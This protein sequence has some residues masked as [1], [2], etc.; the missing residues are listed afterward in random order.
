MSANN[1][2]P[3]AAIVGL[4]GAELGA[5][6]RRLFAKAQPLGFI[7]FARNVETKSQVK[8]LVDDLRR[9][10][11]RNA[12]VLIDQEGGRVQRLKP[13]HWRQAPPA[14]VFGEL[15]NRNVE[16]A[17]AAV[18]LNALLIGRELAELGI[19]VDCA[20]VIDVPSFDAHDV[21]GDRAFGRSPSLVAD[22]GRAAIAGFLDAGVIPMIKHI[23]G[24]GRARVDS[25]E[26]L[27]VVD[28]PADILEQSDFVPFR[29]LADAPMAMTAHIV[30]AAIDAKHPATSS[31]LIITQ[32]I[33]RSM[34]FKGVLVSDDLSMKALSGSYG[35]RTQAALSAGCDA[36][37][38][39]NGH[40]DEMEEVLAHAAPLS[41]ASQ[42][43]LERAY[44]ML[45]PSDED[46]TVA[47][48]ERLLADA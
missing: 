6:E 11:G 10:V 1:G 41:R 4:A 3:K 26:R 31:S 13:P 44:D 12:P 34:G 15:A 30:Y 23:P 5:A 21:I 32:L 42:D 45:S 20:P 2:D 17:R 28:T 9:S 39:C 7:L 19:D 25:H 46:A 36:V 40:M 37:L 29:E 43:R 14:R 38:H 33:R 35:E 24:H 27:P 48:L 22:L 18:R 16:A 47:E 8:A